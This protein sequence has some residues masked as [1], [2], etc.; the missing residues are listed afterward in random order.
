MEKKIALRTLQNIKTGKIFCDEKSMLLIA[1]LGRYGPQSIPSIQKNIKAHCE[2]LKLQNPNRPKDF[3]VNLEYEEIKRKIKRLKKIG[4]INEPHYYFHKTLTRIMAL[5][6]EGLIWYFQEPPSLSKDKIDYFF[7]SYQR[8]YLNKSKHR[9][10]RFLLESYKQ[11]IPFCPLWKGM[12]E[13]IGI[14][15]LSRL[16]F[17]VKNF[18]VDEK[19]CFRIEPLDIE[20]ATYPNYSGE[21]T[22][23]IYYFEKDKMVADFLKNEEATLLRE[24]YISYLINEDFNLLHTMKSDGVK[25]NL[26]QLKSVKEYAFFGYDDACNMSLFSKEGLSKVFPKNYKIEYYFTGMF[27]NNLLWDKKSKDKRGKSQLS[28]V[29]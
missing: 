7:K 8:P 5:T 10:N 13:Q 14:K 28:S 6:F 20:V 4:F 21:S 29:G 2:T 18:C 11:L 26:P 1:I 3:G 27:V 25:Q 12:K 23:K 19:T 15:C 16:T 9:K 24:A 22:D 17:T